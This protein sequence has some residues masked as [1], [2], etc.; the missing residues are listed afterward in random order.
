MK[1]FILDFKCPLGLQRKQ[2][3][4]KI[5]GV[6]NRKRKGDALKFKKTHP[7]KPR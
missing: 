6:T 4:K 5:S 3:W 2:S 1:Y 7:V